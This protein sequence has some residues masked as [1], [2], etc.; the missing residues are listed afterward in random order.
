MIG[1]PGHYVVYRRM[2]NHG[3][4]EKLF[5]GRFSIKGGQLE[6]VEDN[7]AELHKV[8]PPGP[9]DDTHLRRLE[10]LDQS[11]YFMVYHES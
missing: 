7:D 5:L 6:I 11:P 10:Q 8:L 1:E 2:V 9:F 4:V 3:H